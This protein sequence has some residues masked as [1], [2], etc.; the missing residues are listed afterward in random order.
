MDM[1]KQELLELND[2]KVKRIYRGKDWNGK[3]KYYYL[4]VTKQGEYRIRKYDVKD[5][6]SRGA[7]YEEIN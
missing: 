5:F 4:L 2:Y 7:I 6:I 1:K 3:K